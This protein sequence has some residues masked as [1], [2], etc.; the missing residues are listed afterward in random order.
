MKYHAAEIAPGRILI[1]G[2]RLVPLG[3]DRLFVVRVEIAFSIQRTFA[4][5]HTHT[6]AH[7]HTHTS[8][9]RMT[10]LDSR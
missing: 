10:E 5:A 3:N 6:Y 7:T 1:A 2:R 4:S 9:G 8:Q